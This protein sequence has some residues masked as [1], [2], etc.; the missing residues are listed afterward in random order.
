M[1]NECPCTGKMCKNLADVIVAL[2]LH[3]NPKNRFY[4]FDVGKITVRERI[5]AAY[6]FYVNNQ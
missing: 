1:A 6:Q 2:G 5:K 3:Q 4:V